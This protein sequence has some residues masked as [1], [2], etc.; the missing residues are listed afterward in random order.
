MIG[1]FECPIGHPSSSQINIPNMLATPAVPSTPA[2]MR[3]P[4]CPPNVKRARKMVHDEKLAERIKQINAAFNVPPFIGVGLP[5]SQAERRK[6]ELRELDALFDAAE[7]EA[8][9][10]G[11]LGNMGDDVHELKVAQT[12][13]SLKGANWSAAERARIARELVE[14]EREDET[15]Q[16]VEQVLKAIQYEHSQRADRVK[17]LKNAD[18]WFCPV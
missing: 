16:M 3:P 7:R 11:D 13:A 5:V 9:F 2:P 1:P 17:R 4:V 14:F 18:G 6:K 8:A 12:E 10:T 15:E